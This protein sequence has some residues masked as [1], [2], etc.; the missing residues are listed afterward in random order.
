MNRLKRALAGAGLAG[1]IAAGTLAFTAGSASAVTN[2]LV[3]KF[4]A[5]NYSDARSACG[6]EVDRVNQSDING[7]FYCADGG[8]EYKDGRWVVVENEWWQH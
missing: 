8:T 3:N 6:R 7:F 4:Y 5:T 1:A 2:D